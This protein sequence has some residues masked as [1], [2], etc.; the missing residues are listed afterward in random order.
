M[1]NTDDVLII[2]GRY[3]FDAEGGEHRDGA[4]VWVQGERIIGVYGRESP[5]DPPNPESTEGGRLVSILKWPEG[6]PLNLG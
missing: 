4:S 5:P 2:R 1:S 6:A 3:L